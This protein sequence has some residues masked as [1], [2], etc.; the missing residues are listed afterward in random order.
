MK[1]I[2]IIIGILLLLSGLWFLAIKAKNKGLLE[3][4]DGDFIPDVIEDKAEEVKAK[5][6]KVKAKA[7]EVKE[8]INK[9]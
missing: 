3:D 8:V 6:K 2:F 7:K 5:I 9:K 4:K 1:I